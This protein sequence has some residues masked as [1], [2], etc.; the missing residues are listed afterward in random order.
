MRLKMLFKK[1]DRV[2]IQF[3]LSRGG[4]IEG[5]VQV[6]KI[7]QYGAKVYEIYADGMNLI[8]MEKHIRFTKDYYLNEFAKQI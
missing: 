5:T 1:G 2:Q 7:S 3:P 6:A 4:W 8:R